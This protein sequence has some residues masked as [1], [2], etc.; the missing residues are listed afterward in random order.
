MRFCC[1]PPQPLSLAFLL[2][3]QLELALNISALQSV[4]YKR[5]CGNL[6]INH[7]VYI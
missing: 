3:I 4:W 7:W 5:N 6:S 2:C 1:P